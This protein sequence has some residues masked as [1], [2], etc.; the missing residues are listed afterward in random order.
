WRT[1]YSSI[2]DGGCGKRQFFQV[3]MLTSSALVYIRESCLLAV[4][5]KSSLP[6]TTYLAKTCL[7]KSHEREACWQVRPLLVTISSSSATSTHT[8]DRQTFSRCDF[9]VQARNLS[10]HFSLHP[11]LLDHHALLLIAF[12]L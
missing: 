7:P 5:S 2:E 3:L 1:I 6:P 4:P 8:A 12:S 11:R 10:R 9:L